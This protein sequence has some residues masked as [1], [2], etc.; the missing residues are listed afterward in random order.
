MLTTLL[1]RLGIRA[2][3]EPTA[4]APVMIWEGASPFPGYACVPSAH[5][6]LLPRGVSADAFRSNPRWYNH[7][8]A[9]I[10][11][12]RGAGGLW[13]GCVLIGLAI[14]ARRAIATSAGRGQAGKGQAGRGRARWRMDRAYRESPV[15][16]EADARAAAFG[17]VRVPA[18][19]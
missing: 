19:W 3:A 18:R 6:I 16:R 12:A 2:V 10:E 13:L 1:A 14:G 4:G 9:H 5:A 15:E 7:E 11:Q 17:S 8:M